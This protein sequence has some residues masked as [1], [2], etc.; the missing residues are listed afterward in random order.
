MSSSETQSLPRSVARMV[1]AIH[2]L[3]SAELASIF[4]QDAILVD[5]AKQYYGREFI[6]EWCQEAL[7]N[8][9]ATITVKEEK[10]VGNET[11]IRVLMDG[12]FEADYGITEPFT[13]YFHFI[14][15][16]DEIWHLRINGIAPHEPTMRAVWASRGNLENPLWSVRHDI[17]RVPEVPEGW[18][19]VRVAAVG[20]NF[21]DIFTLRGL[22]MHQL[23]FPLV[24][25]NEA[26]GTLEDGTEV[27]I[28][29]VMGNPKFEGDVTMDPIDTS[30]E[31]VPRPGAYW[32]SI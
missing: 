13:L 26:A 11:W 3:N 29:P 2:K 19:K 15:Q 10:T 18:I 23:T 21:P 31:S 6:Q 14:L 20:L 17:R 25:G 5:E 1:Q 32:Q 24:L 27:I 8:R 28:F 22:G 7:V 9:K 12:D 30:L 16:G 4:V